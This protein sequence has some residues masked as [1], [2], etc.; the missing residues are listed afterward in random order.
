[1]GEAINS[2]LAQDVDLEILVI[3]DGSTDETEDVARA[4][5]GPCLRYIRQNRMGAAA[6]R[7]HGATLAKGSLLAFLDADDVWLA[8]K[9]RRQIASLNRGEGDLIFAHIEEF[10][11]PDCLPTLGGL[12][13]IRLQRSGLVATTLLM[14][15]VDFQKLGGFNVECRMGEFIEWYARAVDSDLKSAMIPDVLARRRL[16]NSNTSRVSRG[17]ANQYAVT[18]KR[19]IDRRRNIS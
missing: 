7:N 19:I 6:A 3:D 8:N 2:V 1:L 4:L 10:I 15:N 14:K 18:M 9:L 13:D 5:G 12:V 16:H 11:S 17:Q